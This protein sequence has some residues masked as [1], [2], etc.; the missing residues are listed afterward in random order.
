MQN[1]PE[2]T[3]R[4]RDSKGAEVHKRGLH[5]QS[6]L[7][8]CDPMDCSPPGSSVLEILQARILE[9]VAVPFSWG[10]S[11]P[12]DQTSVWCLLLQR[13]RDLLFRIP[14]VRASVRFFN[15]EKKNLR[16]TIHL[17]QNNHSHLDLVLCNLEGC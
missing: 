6:S 3:H 7:T 11:Q 1:K 8:L 4:K 13:F 9:W 17:L 15:R 12:R 16:V 14:T 10:S 2:E 5:A